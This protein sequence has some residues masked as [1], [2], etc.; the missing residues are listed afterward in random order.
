MEDEARASAN[1]LR[2]KPRLRIRY[3]DALQIRSSRWPEM[4]GYLFLPQQAYANEKFPRDWLHKAKAV[5][6]S[7]QR[8]LSHAKCITWTQQSSP[9][10]VHSMYVGSHNL[11]K[12]RLTAR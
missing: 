5:R 1:E 10:Y 7:A 2:A 4:A 11:S 8:V 12:V 6:T 3:A 9:V